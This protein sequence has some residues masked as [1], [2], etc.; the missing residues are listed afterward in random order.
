MPSFF[1]TV[2]D[3]H[4]QADT[5]RWGRYGVIEVVKGQFRQIRLRPLPKIATVPGILFFGGT[6]HR[7]FPGDRVWLYYNQPRRFSNYLVLKYI[8]SSREGSF[9]SACRALE[10]LDEIA[11]LKRS[12]AV[13][14]DVANWRISSRLMA[15]WGWEPH[16]PSRWHRHYIKRFYGN[17]PP[18]AAWIAANAVLANA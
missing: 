13:L 17:Y 9:S 1:Q 11:R 15:R 16:C 18:P 14:C 5:L 8:V 12:D 3:L 2:T 7:R 4:A 6:C 10:V